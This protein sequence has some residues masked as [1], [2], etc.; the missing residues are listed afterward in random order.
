L[1]VAEEIEHRQWIAGGLCSLGA[2]YVDVLAP[3]RAR[4]LLERALALAHELGSSVWAPYAAARMTMAYT[5]QRDFPKAGATLD[6]EL[7][8][9]TPFESAPQLQLWCARAE[10]ALAR[11]APDEALLI[12]DKL[13]A[14]LSPGKVAPRVWIV[15]G[16]ALAG[17]ASV[18]ESER[19]LTA[20]IDASRASGLRSLLWRAHAA[21]GRLLRTRGRRDEAER[22]VQNARA[23][24]DE[25]A[26]ELT[27]GTLRQAFVERAATQIPPRGLVSERRLKKQA[28]DGLTTREREVAALIAGAC[29]T[30]LSATSWW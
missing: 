10:L 18:E 26:T 30:A 12:A 19:I 7:N 23:L 1:R 11:H 20:A 21:L 3:D 24:V 25:L 6:G 27:D 5:Q 14:S 17:L 15:R 28:F 2:L 9:D 22:H 4:P 8:A 29:P 13:A 16:E